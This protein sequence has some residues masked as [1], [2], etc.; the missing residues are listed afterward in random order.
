MACW[1][2]LHLPYLALEIASARL[3]TD[4]PGMPVDTTVVLAQS[5][6]WQASEAAQAA[7]VQSGMRRGGVLALLPQARFHD[8]DEAAETQALEALALA[9]LRFGPDVAIASPHCVLLDAAP[10]LRL[11]GGLASLCA[12]VLE[13][14]EALGH[15]AS[16]GVAATASAAALLARAASAVPRHV[17]S[18]GPAPCQLQ[19]AMQARASDHRA[20]AG[21]AVSTASGVSAACTAPRAFAPTLPPL[22][23]DLP[24]QLDSLP[25]VLL[26]EAQPWLDWLA[27][28]GCATLGE[29]RGLPTAGVRRRCG[30]A[31]PA[32]LARAYGEAPE[33]PDWYRA[34]P[35]FEAVLPLPSLTHDIEV[36]LFGLRRLLAQLTGWLGAGQL[37][38]RALTLVLEHEPVGRHT[39]AP[40]RLEIRLAEASA[41][42]AHLL[43]LCKER[44]ARSP[45]VAP[46]LTLRLD[47][48]HTSAHEL[49]SGSLL[50]EPGRARQ[51]FVQLMERVAARLGDEQV[52]RLQVREDH[53]PERA[54]AS[55]PYGAPG[56]T[57]C[58]GQ[59]AGERRAGLPPRPAWLLDAPQRLSVLH[60]RPWRQGPLQL[61]S[62]PERIEAGWWEPGTVTR[63]YFIAAD[64][65]GALLWV[66]RERPV[67]GADAAWYLHGLFG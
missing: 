9:L 61:V 48:A 35:H 59:G 23:A 36:L 10:S 7:G 26:P 47:V 20:L 5:R 54:F 45:L 33:A 49:R 65:T 29:L 40:T 46:V 51:D 41:A 1:I 60:E 63:D 43:S 11:F 8:R 44:L 34:P 31:L 22:P 66:F 55:V 17:D 42:P 57:A 53:R 62:G 18:H 37:A 13:S 30:P 27:Q 58:G 50:P 39:L 64:T 25:V 28:I 16:L 52:L 3:Q 2:A 67:Q 14:A 21:I 6:V 19:A 56:S 15:R 4:A 12:Q 38:A 24:K 32:A